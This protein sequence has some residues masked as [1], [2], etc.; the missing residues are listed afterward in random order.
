MRRVWVAVSTRGRLTTG[1]GREHFDYC[2]VFE[3]DNIAGMTADRFLVNE[4]RRNTE[5]I[6]KART[7]AMP[8]TSDVKGI[9]KRSGLYGFLGDTCCLLRGRPI[10]DR[11]T[12]HA[13][14]SR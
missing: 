10:A 2:L 6:Q 4:K 5:N 11:Y 14:L 12:C 7:I 9:G 8:L 3:Y 1:K 13:E